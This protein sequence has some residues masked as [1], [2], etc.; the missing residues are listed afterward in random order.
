LIHEINATQTDSIL[1]LAFNHSGSL[2]A[3]GSQDKT[4]VL[5]E[6]TAWSPVGLALVG[7]TDKVTALAFSPDGKTLA[8]GGADNNL[9]LWDL[10]TLQ[11]IGQPFSGHSRPITAL[12]F[13]AN[14]SSLLSGD[15]R[16]D[17]FLWTTSPAAWAKRA[18][19]VAKRNLT[20]TEWDQFMAVQAGA[21]RKTCDQWAEAGE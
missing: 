19:E 7:H 17:L 9:I 14:G 20:R 11:R 21:Y 8:S 16:G 6:T 1:S 5:W 2:L 18:C 3:T 15:D 10:F 12:A 4:I 13:N